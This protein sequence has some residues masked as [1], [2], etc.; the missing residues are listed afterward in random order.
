M[1]QRIIEPVLR[2]RSACQSLAMETTDDLQRLVPASG[3]GRSR[4]VEEA[5]GYDDAS[6]NARTTMTD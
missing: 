6:Y 2:A 4:L 1:S 3:V 5:G